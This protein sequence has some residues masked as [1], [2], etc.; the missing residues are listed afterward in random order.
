MTIYAVGDIQG[1]YDQ[2]K[3]LL[4]QIKFDYRC[5]TLWLTGDLVNRG[6]RSLDVLR[7]IKSL[8]ECAVT[9]LGNHDLHLLAVAYGHEPAKKSDTLDDILTADDKD[10]L[11]FWLRN[12]PLLHRDEIRKLT[13]VHAGLAPQWSMDDAVTCAREAEQVLRGDSFNDFLANMYGN[14][15]VVWGNKLAGWDRLRFIVN[16]FTR[17]R[18]VNR[19]NELELKIKGSPDKQ[20]DEFVPWFKVPDRKTSEQR[21]L[22]GHW[23][24]LGYSTHQSVVCLDSGCLWGGALTAINVDNLVAGKEPEPVSLNCPEQQKP[25][26]S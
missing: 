21:I 9:V 20:S 7:F 1:C 23:S 24:T 25:A 18:Y 10:E 2:L 6:P 17:L 16:C 15:P 4:D 3:Q 11:L 19:K 13:L 12:R 22:F 5:D 8:G 26:L 14:Q